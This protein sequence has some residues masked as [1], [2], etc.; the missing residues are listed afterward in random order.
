MVSSMRSRH[1][2]H[3][4]SSTREEV[5]GGSGFVLS[6]AS[7][8]ESTAEDAPAGRGAE[9]VGRAE[10]VKGSLFILGKLEGSLSASEVWNSIDLTKTTWQFSG[11]VL[12]VSGQGT[13][14]AR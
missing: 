5:G 4:G 3:V 9:G 14:F 13:D 7:E 10:G 11:C 8:P 2:G 6:D 12:R 1:T